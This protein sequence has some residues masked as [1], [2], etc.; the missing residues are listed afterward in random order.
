MRHMLLYSSVIIYKISA[1]WNI[2]KSFFLPEGTVCIHVVYLSYCWV[3]LVNQT[4]RGR[5]CEDTEEGLLVY[6]WG[7]QFGLGFSQFLA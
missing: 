6:L 7:K 4:P 1:E 2:E 3:L 5:Y